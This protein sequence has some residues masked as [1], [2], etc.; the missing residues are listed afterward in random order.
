[1]RLST[2]RGGGQETRVLYISHGINHG[3]AHLGWF[4]SRLYLSNAGCRVSPGSERRL[5]R[6]VITT[7][8]ESVIWAMLL[9]TPPGDQAQKFGTWAAVP[10]DPRAVGSKAPPRNRK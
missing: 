9:A 7:V 1:M 4:A 5:N 6:R 8:E 2:K 3:D 10:L